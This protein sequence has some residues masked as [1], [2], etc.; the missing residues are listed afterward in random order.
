MIKENLI[1]L[2]RY[3]FLANFFWF[4]FSCNN[5]KTSEKLKNK[6]VGYVLKEEDAG[7]DNDLDDDIEIDDNLGD[8]DNDRGISNFNEEA[9]KKQKEFDND[10]YDNNDDKTLIIPKKSPKKQKSK[11]TNDDKEYE[12]TLNEMKHTTDD[13]ASKYLKNYN[14][15]NDYRK[16]VNSKLLNEDDLEDK[17]KKYFNDLNEIILALN[18]VELI[19]K[20]YTK[21]AYEINNSYLDDLD[22]HRIKIWKF[23]FQFVENKNRN[24]AGMPTLVR[25]LTKYTENTPYHS[26]KGREGVKQLKNLFSEQIRRHIRF[27]KPG[28]NI[29]DR[30]KI[31]AEQTKLDNMVTSLNLIYKQKANP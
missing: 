14:T 10:D 6:E 13:I 9:K 18:I 3:L 12:K 7:R 2:F 28:I 22:K 24:R 16:D 4:L 20:N 31:K 29:L 8:N 19:G 17:N 30:G 1:I 23:L 5:D 25:Y 21:N 26:F 11:D 15:L 27:Y